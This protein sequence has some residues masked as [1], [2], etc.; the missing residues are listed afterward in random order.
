M[1]KREDCALY[2]CADNKLLWFLSLFTFTFN[3]GEYSQTLS[4]TINTNQPKWLQ[5]RHTFNI[6][7]EYMCVCACVL[8]ALRL[9]YL[10]TMAS[11]EP[12]GWS[13]SSVISPPALW[14]PRHIDIIS[15]PVSLSVSLPHTHKHTYTLSALAVHT[16]THSV[17]HLPS[18]ALSQTVSWL[19]WQ[20]WGSLPPRCKAELLAMAVQGVRLSASPLTW[21]HW[22][23]LYGCHGHRPPP[24]SDKTKKT[25]RQ[26]KRQ[27]QMPFWFLGTIKTLQSGPASVD[28][29][30]VGR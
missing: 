16:C 19:L 25:S 5:M 2:I 17:S 10:I 15:Y 13:V 12:N 22:G 24:L 21:P 11:E 6:C 3:G 23:H 28:S 1:H 29:C 14:P 7:A 27:R 8:M 20:L 30:N 26:S 4:L 18:P 9:S